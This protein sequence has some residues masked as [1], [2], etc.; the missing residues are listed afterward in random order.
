MTNIPI[1]KVVFNKDSFTKVINNQFNQLLNNNLEQESTE[2]TLDDF[3]Q[4][5]NNFFYQI[6]RE[7]DINSHNYI[8]QK[9]AE[10]MGVQLNDD[11]FKLLLEEITNLRQE[12]LDSQNIISNLTNGQ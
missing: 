12:L 6:P 10:Y 1:Q 11:N 9:E 7:G 3:F 2:I 8:L 5:Y 4:L